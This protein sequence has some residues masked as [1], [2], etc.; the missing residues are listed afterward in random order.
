MKLDKPV[1]ELLFRL[2][3]ELIEGI[4][5]VEAENHVSL[6]DNSVVFAHMDGLSK[7][8]IFRKQF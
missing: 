2:Y 5:V 8:M 3:L 1:I 4:R 6:G 7:M